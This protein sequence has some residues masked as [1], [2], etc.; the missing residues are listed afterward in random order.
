ASRTCAVIDPAWDA[1]SILR[2]AERLDVTITR[3]LCTHGHFDHVDQVEAL[4]HT[5]DVPV[6]MLREEIDCSGF[7]C[8]N[9][10]PGRPGDTV[11]VGE[12]VD[13]TLMHTPGHT[14]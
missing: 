7:H 14:P 13:V 4:L 9:L 12:H 6:H 1:A 8:D 3:I 10:V 11:R 2:E 5:V